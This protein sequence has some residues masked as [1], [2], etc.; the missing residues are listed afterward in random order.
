MKNVIHQIDSKNKW[1]LIPASFRAKSGLVFVST[2]KTLFLR[3]FILNPTERA[4]VVLKNSTK[5]LQNSPPFEKLAC[6]YITENFKRFQ[7]F[8]LS[9]L[10]QIEQW[11]QN[12]PTTKNGVFPVANTCFWKFCFS[13]IWC[14]SDPN[15]HIRTFCKRLSFILWCFFPVSILN[16]I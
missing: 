12:G 2:L 3:G 7:Y 6:F 15:A 1:L 16:K 9:M 8:N 10:R 4:K 13:L 11:L 14:T 5:D